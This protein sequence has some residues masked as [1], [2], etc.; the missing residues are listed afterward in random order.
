MRVCSYLLYF[1]F[2]AKL[3]GLNTL[4]EL[5]LFPHVSLNGEK[6]SRIIKTIVKT[7]GSGRF[8]QAKTVRGVLLLLPTPNMEAG[9]NKVVD[10]LQKPAIP[11]KCILM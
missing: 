11:Q 10:I 9:V 6:L 2:R 1:R 4:T 5:L 3:T 8:W 7:T